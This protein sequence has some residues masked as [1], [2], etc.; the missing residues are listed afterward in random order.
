MD[1]S[2]LKHLLSF[3]A[4]GLVQVF[5]L[6]HIS[7]YGVATPLLYIFFVLKMRRNYPRWAIIVESFVLGLLMDTFQN[8]PGVGACS[9][10]LLGM[11]Q[12]V[13]LDLFVTRELAEDAR[14]SVAELGRLKYFYYVTISTVIYCV[15][16]YTLEMFAFFNWMQWIE[17]IVGSSVLTILLI[18]LLEMAQKRKE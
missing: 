1:F 7:L 6:N 15:A 3:L 13:L 17:R 16:F 8:T 12:H 10:T 5:V 14:P 9:M 4:L 18:M 2:Y 11:I